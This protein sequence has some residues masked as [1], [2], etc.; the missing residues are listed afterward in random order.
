MW[1]PAGGHNCTNI[2][3]FEHDSFLFIPFVTSTESTVKDF[4][5]SLS[6]TGS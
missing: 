4:S 5:K 2:K 1:K 3:K 6:E